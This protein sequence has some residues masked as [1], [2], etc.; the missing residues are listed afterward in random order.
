MAQRGVGRGSKRIKLLFF[1][2]PHVGDFFE[3][4]IKGEDTEIGVRFSP[5][6]LMA[7]GRQLRWHHDS[8]GGY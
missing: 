2:E 4:L 5:H 8:A 6:L 3:V 7:T 1:V